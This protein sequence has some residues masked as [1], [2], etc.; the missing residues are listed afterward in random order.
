MPSYT[1]HYGYAEDESYSKASSSKFLKGGKASSEV[2]L[3]A[4]AEEEAQKAELE[5]MADVLK[6]TNVLGSEN[7]VVTRV[8][9]PMRHEAEDHLAVCRAHGFFGEGEAAEAEYQARMAAVGKAQTAKEVNALLRDLPNKGFMDPEPAPPRV[10]VSK[11]IATK[12]KHSTPAKVTASLAGAVLAAM[13]GI[14]PGVSLAE[15]HVH[16][17]AGPIAALAGSIA[18]GVIGFIVAIASLCVT[19]DN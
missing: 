13:I 16:M 12:Y 9:N 8:G 17:W 10:G 5:R 3:R 11:A 14:V 19:L 2:S 6:D 1:G 18:I 7:R 15:S 4:S